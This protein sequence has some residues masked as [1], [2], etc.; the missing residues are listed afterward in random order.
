MF[1]SADFIGISKANMGIRKAAVTRVR[2]SE[3][4]G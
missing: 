2:S 4:G 3:E 1:V